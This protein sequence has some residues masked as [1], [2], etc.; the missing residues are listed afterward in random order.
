MAN[1]AYAN[2]WI[3]DFDEA[4]RIERL[5]LLLATTPFSKTRPGFRSLV[6]RAVEPSLPPIAEYE[7][8]AA[9]VGAAE[10]AD[11]V[12]EHAHADAAYEVGAY[13]DL[14]I[15]DA[16]SG[17]W[18]DLPQR[19]E[20]SSYGLEYDD[21]LAAAESGHFQIEFGLEHFF[22]GHA[23]L[24]GTSAPRVVSVDDPIE[25]E[26]LAAMSRPENLRGY[27]ERT[28]ENIQRLMR[29]M[30]AA[31]AALPIERTRLWSEGEENFEA[32]LD[33]ILAVR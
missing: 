8:S 17:R 19:A 4:T 27:L 2:L 13:Q 9:P 14:W 29:W 11:L 18:S 6:I 23:G 7:L 32:R 12:R 24:L 15:R 16:E 1:R 10:I 25:Q 21:G 3:R 28:R 5:A 31:Q 33:E 22:T 30:S 26:F 20:I